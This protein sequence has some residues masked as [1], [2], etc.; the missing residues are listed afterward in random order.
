MPLSIIGAGFGRTGTMSLYAALNQLGFPCYHLFANFRK[1][2]IDSNLAFWRR[3]ANS[4]DGC[5]HDWEKVFAGY[6][7]CV[8]NPASCVW[9]ELATA[10]PQAKIILTV[11]PKGPEAWYESTVDTNYFFTGNSWQF[12]VLEIATPLGRQIGEISRKLIWQRSHR[13]TMTEQARAISHYRNYIEDVKAALPEK[14]LLVFS[15]DQG[16]DPLCEF[17]GVDVPACAFPHLNDRAE[18]K[19]LMAGLMR[20]T[21]GPIDPEMIFVAE[22][23]DSVLLAVKNAFPQIDW[24][25]EYAEFRATRDKRQ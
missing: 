23:E 11:H 4:P 10:Y 8:D 22:S 25:K 13:G 19:N 6:T 12:R 15:V 18:I 14:R 5:Q 21:I 3:V 1:A 20:E 9:R 2:A 17:L 16:W 24:E 7:A